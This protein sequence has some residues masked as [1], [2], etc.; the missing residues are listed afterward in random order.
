MWLEKG[1]HSHLS[2]QNQ[3]NV[4]FRKSGRITIVTFKIYLIFYLKISKI[5]NFSQ[6][7]S[8]SHILKLV[9][10]LTVHCESVSFHITR[11]GVDYCPHGGTIAS[12][13]LTYWE[14][15]NEQSIE[16]YAFSKTFKV[17]GNIEA[18]IR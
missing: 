3:K 13:L 11:C 2:G 9:S 14:I 5:H 12:L 4:Y 8:T 18:V 6:F 15:I 10:I 1:F 17:F 7:L 16:T